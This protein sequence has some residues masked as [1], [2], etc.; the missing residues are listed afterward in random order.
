MKY[1][2]DKFFQ[3]NITSNSPLYVYFPVGIIYYEVG[4]HYN[5]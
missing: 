1:V 4:M 5:I 2:C 3:R